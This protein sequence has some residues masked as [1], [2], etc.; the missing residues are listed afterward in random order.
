MKNHR[1]T[2]I[3]M[4]ILASSALVSPAMSA[5]KK[6]TAKADYETKMMERVMVIGSA[7]RAADITGSATYLEEEVIDNFNYT[8]V[9]RVL[10][11]VPG[12]NIQEEEGFG[13]R[14]NIGIRGGRSERSAD[15]TLMEDGVL[16]APAPYASPSAYYFP[17]MQRMEGIEVRKGSSTIKFGP[18]TTSGAVNF[19]S[20]SIPAEEEGGVTLGYGTHNTQQGHFHYGNTVDNFGFV[21]DLGH[22]ASDGFKDLD[23][24]GGDTG[25]SI[26]DVMGKFRVTSDDSADIYHSLELKLGYTQEDSDETYLGLTNADFRADPFRRY[27]G[28]QRDNMDSDHQTYQIRHFVDFNGKADLTTTFYRNDFARNWYKGQSVTIGGTKLNYGP[29][30][31]SSNHLAALRGEL[32]LDGSAGNNIR[33]RTN[34]REYYSQGIQTDFATGFATGGVSHDL[35]IGARFHMDE[36]DRFQREDLYSITSGVMALTETGIPGSQANREGRAEAIA[37]YVQDEIEW[38]DFTVVPGFRYEHISLEREDFNSGA[39]LNNTVDAFVPGL[40]VAYALNDSLSFFGGVHK[41]FA[42]PG[43]GST[44]AQE[45]ESVNYEAGVRFNDGNV[46]AELAGFFN[47]YDNLLG[48]CTN[49]SGCTSAAQGDQFNA[50]EVEAHGIEASIAYD[51]AGVLGFKEVSVPLLANYTYTS[52]EFQNTFNSNFDEWGSVSAG[53]ELPY[54]PEHQFYVSAGLEA[55]QWRAQLGGKFVSAMRT[56]A[57]SGNIPLGEGTDAHFVVDASAEY[58]V[59]ENTRAF[60]NA[61]NL[62]DQEYVAARRPAGARPGAPQTFLAGVKY[63]F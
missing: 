46:S 8:D 14:P 31:G 25:Y 17:R 5:D 38:G 1:I 18:R 49:S 53:D 15:I 24:T 37:L 55:D 10:R 9:N 62:F 13:T 35:E 41:G 12:V 23:V 3:A 58:E 33:L 32:D 50:G 11:Q 34:N 43:T 57:G 61:Y 27:A 56:T 40:G 45:E 60:V 51:A 6:L 16:V 44:D 28:S 63:S 48:E 22:E 36:E 59:L 26:Q 39:E 19:I 52:A 21:F 20:R 2:T 29:A 42:P 30:L 4:A 54:I 47:D 7:D